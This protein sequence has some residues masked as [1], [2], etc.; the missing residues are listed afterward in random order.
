MRSLQNI[1]NIDLGYNREHLLMVTTDPL[2]AG[3]NHL[4][5]INFSNEMI[6]R[7]SNLP[8]VRAVSYSKNGLFSGSESGNSIKVE[9]YV[10]KNEADLDAAFD[11]IGPGYFTAVG[12]P[13][14][15]GRDVGLQD[16]ETA[17]N[18][19]VINETMAKF[20]FGANSPIGRKFTIDDPEFQGRQMEIVGVSRDARDHALKGKISRRFYIP[21]M[22]TPRAVPGINFEIRTVGNPAAVAEEVR[23]Q[24]KSMD[25]NV[26]LY[27]IRALGELT[28]RSI[29]DEI[30]IARLSGFFAGLALLLAAIG[31]YGV[32]SYSVAGRT[33]EIGVRMAPRTA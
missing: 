13:M 28:E 29:N 19:A 24:I 7:L 5:I 14:L 2:A 1:R 6:S 23:K 30:L 11:E 32:L 8:G 20:Y 17:P 16:M 12:I 4:Q 27:D 22:Q 3:Y 10:A 31:L 25:E 26:P 18:V 9:G 33:R 21:A 15:L